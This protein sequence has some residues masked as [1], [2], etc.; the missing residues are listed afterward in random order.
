MEYE[1]EPHTPAGLIIMDTVYNTRDLGWRESL[2][3]AQCLECQSGR[4]RFPHCGNA[5][6]HAETL[7]TKMR[8]AGTGER[9]LNV[10]HVFM[11]IH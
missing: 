5:A 10:C 9:T 4:R 1:T 3:G 2:G 8:D 11:E 7:N 6:A